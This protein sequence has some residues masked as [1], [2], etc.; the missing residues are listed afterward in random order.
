MERKILVAMDDSLHTKTAIN[1]AAGL[2]PV[3]RDLGYKLLHVQPAVSDY[4]MEEA[5]SDPQAY[6]E[7]KQMMAGYHRT[8][9]RILS[10]SKANLIS[11]GVPESSIETFTMPRDQGVAKDI[12]DYSQIGQY[13]AI[14]MGRRGLSGI[15][16]VFVGSVSSNV[17]ENST[18]IPVWLVAGKREKGD[19]LL[20]VDGS[21]TSLRAVDHAAFM[22]GGN[23]DAKI[24]FYH[25]TPKLKSY[26]PIDLEEEDAAKMDRIIEQS[27]RVCL[28][29]FLDRA[30]KILKDAGIDEDRIDVRVTSGMFR[31]GKA[32]LEEYTRGNFSTLVIGR[33]GMDKKYFTGSV[34]RYL[35]N[36][37]SDGA[38]WVVP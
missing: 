15:S 31:V 20:A 4:L 11:K 2:F 26:C 18:L 38:L 24:V 29:R 33:R 22:L 21:K 19:F 23:T 35:I 7:L 16:E 17:V 3:M 13:D 14:V 8:A 9:Q 5:K 30:K 37:F 25:V 10:D 28:D 12:L 27:D 6:A 32:I 34:S 1:Y 36:Q